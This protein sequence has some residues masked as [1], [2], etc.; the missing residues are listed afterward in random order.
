MPSDKDWR[1]IPW[2]DEIY[3]EETLPSI[4]ALKVSICLFERQGRARWSTNGC[5]PAP[6]EHPGA[7]SAFPRPLQL[8]LCAPT[9][10]GFEIQVN[11]YPYAVFLTRHQA[12]LERDVS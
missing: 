6:T 1:L 2:Q 9:E 3:M 4:F 7:N 10:R 5:L 12:V 8:M 11:V